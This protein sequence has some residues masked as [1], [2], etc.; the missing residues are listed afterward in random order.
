MPVTVNQAQT[1]ASDLFTHDALL[2]ILVGIILLLAM[3]GPVSL[4]LNHD[5]DLNR[6]R[7]TK[8]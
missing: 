6:I 4:S 8:S 3:I 1:L 7:S 5:A 2:L